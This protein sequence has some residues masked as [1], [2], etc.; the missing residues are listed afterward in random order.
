VAL[1]ATELLNQWHEFICEYDLKS[2]V[3]RGYG[4]LFNSSV[5]SGRLTNSQLRL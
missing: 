2:Y 4:Q 5:R 3:T 1:A